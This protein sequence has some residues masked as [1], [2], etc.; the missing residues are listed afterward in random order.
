MVNA[1]V[2]EAGQNL[3]GFWRLV[4]GNW[5][6]ST[7]KISLELSNHKTPDYSNIVSM[8]QP[9]SGSIR[10]HLVSNVLYLRTYVCTLTAKN[11]LN[12]GAFVASRSAPFNSDTV[13]VDG[14]GVSLLDILKHIFSLC[15]VIFRQQLK[16][17]SRFHLKLGYRS[18]HFLQ[19]R[20]NGK[21]SARQQTHG[22]G[23]ANCVLESAR[24]YFRV[25]GMKIEK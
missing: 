23:V 2:H 25:V 13:T 18:W 11:I 9:K 19:T 12:P 15:L 17:Q 8:V 14:L 1:E 7:F 22:N 21:A 10:Q 5:S 4:S 3:N 16:I 20:K 6:H 24:Y